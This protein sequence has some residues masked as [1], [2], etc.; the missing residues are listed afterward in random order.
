MRVLL[1]DRVAV[2]T[3]GAQGLG[4]GI[5]V[6]LAEE[7]AHVAVTDLR[8]DRCAETAAMVEKLGVRAAALAMD[9]TSETSVAEAFDAIVKDFGHLHVLVNNAGVIKMNAMLDISASDYDAT[10]NVN[11]KGLF[12]CSQLAAKHMIRQDEGGAIVNIASNAGKVGYPNMADYNAS[13][14]AV[15]NL[16]RTMAAELSPHGIN[17]NA[18]CPGG[19]RTDMLRGVADWL[20]ERTGEDAKKLYDQFPPEKLGRLIEPVEVGRVVAFLA[21]ERAHIIRGQAINVDGGETPY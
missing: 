12:L 19:V 7:G 14:A 16:T 18:V 1:K 3:G 20:A 9:V 8:Q 6:A 13:K 5:A 11:V 21:S 17:V 10:F 15:I 2:V 4:R